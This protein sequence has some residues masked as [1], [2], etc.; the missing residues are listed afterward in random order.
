MA[1]ECK[2]RD[3]ACPVEVVDAPR[4]AVRWR[5]MREEELAEPS[6]QESLL[7]IRRERPNAPELTTSFA[8]LI[9]HASHQLGAPPSGFIFHVSRCGSTLVANALRATGR[10][11]V[12]SEAGAINALLRSSFIHSHK[13]ASLLLR[14]ALMLLGNR[15]STPR[16][17]YVVKFTSWNLFQIQHIRWLWPGVP[18]IFLY[19]QPNSVA[20]SI[21]ES[22]V[23]WMAGHQSEEDC[24]DLG[25]DAN[26]AGSA[27]RED[28][29]ARVLGELAGKALS[30]IDTA[31]AV[32]EYEKICIR[33]LVRVSGLFGEEL[34]GAE[35]RLLEQSLSID[36]KDTLQVKPFRPQVRAHTAAATRAIDRWARVHFDRLPQT[37][38]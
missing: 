10:F 23:G 15:V 20:A 32:I 16:R 25:I 18:W 27:T 37:T 6:F 22:P 29:V 8:S 3:V 21:L 28:Y 24:R 2:F 12:I 5:D 4:Y 26:N 30:V 1:P 17:P 36:S 38:V 19:R 9:S 7:R 31:A 11:K 35:L 34:S 14:N 13:G 33:V